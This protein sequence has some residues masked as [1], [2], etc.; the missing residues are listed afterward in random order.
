M[1]LPL[2]FQ[3]G[4]NLTR[5]FAFIIYQTLRSTFSPTLLA[6]LI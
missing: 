4:Y 1:C 2:V 3:F 5:S 6:D